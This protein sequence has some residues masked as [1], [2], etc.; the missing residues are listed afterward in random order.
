MVTNPHSSAVTQNSQP[1]TTLSAKANII[2][3]PKTKKRKTKTKYVK[4][5]K[6]N[7]KNQI[8]LEAANIPDASD[9]SRVADELAELRCENHNLTLKNRELSAV[10]EKF[11]TQLGV[12]SLSFTD[13]VLR[14]EITQQES[15]AR[16]QL[17]LLSPWRVNSD[18]VSTVKQNSNPILSDYWERQA[19][20][21][22][23]RYRAL[24]DKFDALKAIVR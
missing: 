23:E 18:S 4:N 3:K 21:Y 14:R 20:E 15:T 8:A 2:D 13:V 11:R 6:A 12:L 5:A 19:R 9:R 17:K 7:A 10:I 16:S 24:R 1:L 22:S